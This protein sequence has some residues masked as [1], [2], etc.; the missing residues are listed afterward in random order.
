MALS[1]KRFQRDAKRISLCL[2]LVLT[3][4]N[5]TSCSTI[6]GTFGYYTD[7]YS[8]AF[9]YKGQ[10]SNWEQWYFSLSS[11]PNIY[12][13]TSE[14]KHIIGLAL[15]DS[16]DNQFFSFKITNYTPGK[17]DFIGTVSYYVNDQYPDAEKLAR[18]NHFV[19]PNHRTD[20]TP[21]VERTA[22]AK[23][24]IIN[25]GAPAV[26][27]IWFDDIGIAFDVRRVYWYDK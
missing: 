27:N 20:T 12:E 3:L 7:H 19:I 24:K 25:D 16:G 13:I 2:S 1:I 10:W 23:I 14:E 26:F 21:S 15:K 5:V 6:K 11:T 17:K 8:T 18:Y 9:C 22:E 4:L